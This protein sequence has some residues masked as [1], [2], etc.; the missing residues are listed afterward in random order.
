[1]TN[2]NC[3]WL[4]KLRLISFSDNAGHSTFS[5]LD[6]DTGLCVLILSLTLSPRLKELRRGS[7]FVAS[8]GV[9]ASS[10]EATELR[11]RVAFYQRL[12]LTQPS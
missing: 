2:H 9:C 8:L 6:L 12:N 10:G 7:S 11:A 4:Q 1:M 5:V 3:S